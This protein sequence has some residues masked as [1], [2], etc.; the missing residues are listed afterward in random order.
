MRFSVFVCILVIF[1]DKN[2]KNGLVDNFGHENIVRN[3]NF[4][5]NRKIGH[6]RTK[7][8]IFLFQSKEFHESST[9]A[10]FQVKIMILAEIMG[11]QRFWDLA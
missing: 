1:S 4:G 9:L 10:K 6:N 3:P 5:Q 7:F 8:R 2:T 11:N